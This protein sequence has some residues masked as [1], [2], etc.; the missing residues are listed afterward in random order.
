MAQ[1]Q[2]PWFGARYCREANGSYRVTVG[3]LPDVDIA[4][5][6]RKGIDRAVRARIAL[7]LDVGVDDFD[8]TVQGVPKRP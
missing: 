6:G 8:V 5:T 4:V 2:R 3:E 7:V 1:G